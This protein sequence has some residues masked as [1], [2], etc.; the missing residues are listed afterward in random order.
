MWFF[1]Y[2]PFIEAGS[3]KAKKLAK[4]E[5][6]LEFQNT[7]VNLV[8]LAL[9]AFKWENLPE[10]CNERFLELSLLFDGKA[11]IV[12][13]SKYGYLTLK[14]GLDG[15]CLNPYGEVS[16]LYGT[17]VNGF[18]KLYK[19]YMQGSENENCQ[20]VLCRDNDFMYPYYLYLINYTKRL[21]NALRSID[22]ATKKLKV[23][24]F[25]TCEETQ[26]NGVKKILSDINNNEE[27]IIVNKST[28]PDI[29]KVLPTSVDT[30]ILTVL[31]NSY[32]NYDSLIKNII[33]INT[34]T[35]KDKAERLLVDEVNAQSTIS[36][37]NILMRLK[38]RKLFCKQVNEIFGLNIDVN[39]NMEMIENGELQET[40]GDTGIDA[41]SSSELDGNDIQ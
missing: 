35:N 22:V 2:F 16:K 34:G 39:L 15:S 29:F 1:N 37:I 21:S 10:T 28:M 6:D 27:S 3:I 9:Y 40:R 19:A 31:W 26:Y 32:N 18:N 11:C 17:G 24:Y 8:N 4:F 7:F 30:N 20:A 41:P 36:D 13:D 14:A 12:N 25:I 23:P 38:T 5:N 33:G